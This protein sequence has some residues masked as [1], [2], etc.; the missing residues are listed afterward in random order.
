MARPATSGG[1]T[2]VFIAG[3]TSA[4]AGAVARLLAEQGAAF[5]LVG[6]NPERLAAVRDDL[7]VRTGGLVEAAAA[8]LDDLSRHQALVAEAEAFLGGID[9]ALVAHGFLGDPEQVRRDGAAAGRVLHTNLVSPASLLTALAVRMEARGAG[10]LV[11]LSSV[12][13]DRGRQSNYP[14]G[15]A[16]GGLSLFLQGLR[17]RLARRGV[18]VLTAKLGFVD[19]PMTAAMQKN[20]LYASP[21]AV[22]RSLLRAV[23]RRRDVAYLPWFWRPIM[24]LIRAIPER[25]FKRLSL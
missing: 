7:R 11:A 18:H 14:Y 10:T 5:F 4:V 20:P 16:K 24:T 19:T 15:A 13:G 3:A 2:R 25:L 9:L 23:R 6:R 8:D 17:N 22:A 21:E 1:P 12:A